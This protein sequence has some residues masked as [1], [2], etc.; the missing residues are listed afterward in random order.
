ME[1]DRFWLLLAQIAPTDV[2]TP[3]MWLS[4]ILATAVVALFGLYTKK[5]LDNEREWR[6]TAKEAS[7]ELPN[8]GVT[9]EKSVETLR[10]QQALIEAQVRD[11]AA[12]KETVV[13]VERHLDD[14]RVAVAAPGATNR[15]RSTGDQ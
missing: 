14:L 3:W 15:R 6:A 10:V 9:L 11:I 1:S 13:R 4:G 7:A 12:L 5:L 8:M 2:N